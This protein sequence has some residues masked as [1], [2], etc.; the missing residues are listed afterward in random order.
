MQIIIKIILSVLFL[1]C[2]FKMPYYYFSLVRILG[3]TGFALLAYS[4]KDK[5]DKSWMV[6]WIISAFVVNPILKIPLGRT[7]W[8]L[9]DLLWIVL[10]V[11]S[12]LSKKK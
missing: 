8:N 10:F 3:M 4:E 2:L 6:I 9:I 1:G 7:L 5:D 12:E 11:I